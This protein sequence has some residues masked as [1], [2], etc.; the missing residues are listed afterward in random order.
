MGPLSRNAPC[1]CGSGR[2]AKGCCAPVLEGRPAVTAEAL[3]RS[4]YVAY[5]TGAVGHV[6]ATTAPESP[7]RAEDAAAWREEL[8]TYC[9]AVT[10]EGLEVRD[11]SEDGDRGTVTFFARL[12]AGERDLSFGERSRFVR[13]GGRWWYVDGD[14][15]TG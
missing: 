1:P 5:A 10:F 6:M 2:K 4:R 12:R 14:R 8:A 9:A 15:L 13:R 3:M 7:H 11:A